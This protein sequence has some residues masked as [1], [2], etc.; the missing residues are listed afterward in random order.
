MDEE[1]FPYS[2]KPDQT[3]PDLTGNMGGWLTQS[4]NLQHPLRLARGFSSSTQ[5]SRPLPALVL[6]QNHKYY[7]CLS[8]KQRNVLV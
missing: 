7:S 8:Q 1:L 3:D 4:L 6:A 2:L 5:H